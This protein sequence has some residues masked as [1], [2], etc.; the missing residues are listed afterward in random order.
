MMNLK[1]YKKKKDAERTRDPVRRVLEMSNNP[2]PK[3][4]V[5]R[6]VSPRTLENAQAFGMCATA[7]KMLR[8]AIGPLMDGIHDPTVNQRLVKE[9]MKVIRNNPTGIKSEGLKN[10]DLELLM[11]FKFNAKADLFARLF[12]A[13]RSTINRSDRHMTMAIPSFDSYWDL[14]VPRGATHY[15]FL[16]AGV[17]ADFAKNTFDSEIQ[18]T[19]FLPVGV[20][21]SR[22][23][24]FIHD[25]GVQDSNTLFMVVALKFYIK[26]G[27]ELLPVMDKSFSPVNVV[28]VSNALR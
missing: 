26:C 14:V 4:P 6:K 27:T 8:N 24:A 11:G 12:C 13:Y 17:G 15:Q 1:I 7:A 22:P 28:E 25:V 5:P 18:R 16:S 2:P 21:C 20:K 9:L 3:E 23:V 10:G 19:E